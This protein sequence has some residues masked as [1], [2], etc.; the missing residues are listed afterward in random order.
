MIWSHLLVICQTRMSSIF[1]HPENRGISLCDTQLQGGAQPK[2]CQPGFGATQSNID[3]RPALERQVILHKRLWQLWNDIIAFFNEQRN[4]LVCHNIA[5]GNIDYVIG[6]SSWPSKCR[7]SRSYEASLIPFQQR[8]LQSGCW[9]YQGVGLR[10]KVE[11]GTAIHCTGCCCSLSSAGVG[12]SEANT[13]PVS[14]VKLAPQQVL[15]S[16]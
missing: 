5:F 12:T 8:T 3:F 2:I 1:Q 4:N 16:V 10:C 11:D 15:L 6:V 14:W 13:G 9:Y 7:S